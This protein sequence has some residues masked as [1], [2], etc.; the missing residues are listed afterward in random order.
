MLLH[1]NVKRFRQD[2]RFSQENIAEELHM[3]QA[4]YSR[5]ESSETL[6]TR[7]LPEIA[8]ALNTTPEDLRQYHRY[9]SEADVPSET[10]EERLAHQMELNRNLIEEN[11]FLKAQVEYMQSVWHHHHYKGGKLSEK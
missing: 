7:Y 9:T 4:S 10:L 8:K 5:I 11:R 6:C 2:K 1:K 3:T